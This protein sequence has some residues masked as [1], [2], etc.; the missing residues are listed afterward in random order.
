MTRVVQVVN[1][2]LDALERARDRERTLAAR[3]SE[4][5][6]V[7]RKRLARR[8]SWTGRPSFSPRLSCNSTWPS[9]ALPSPGPPELEATWAGHRGRAE[10]A[11]DGARGHRG[12]SHAASVPPSSTNSGRREPSRSRPATSPATR[13]VQGG[14]GGGFHRSITWRRG[15]ARHVPD[16]RGGASRTPS[17]HG[18]PTRVRIRYRLAPDMRARSSW[19]TTAP[20]STPPWPCCTAGSPPGGAAD[21]RAGPLRRG[22]PG[23]GRSLP[24]K[25]TRLRLELP[26]FAD[27]A[28]GA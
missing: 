20:A 16:P 24:G 26:R 6:E 5:E 17:E 2:M 11:L 21:A 1:R 8:N 9:A 7:E 14:G 25:G 13:N 19:R 18:D 28:V 22:A 15:G 3:V 12:A 23:D 27:P 10:D 4:A